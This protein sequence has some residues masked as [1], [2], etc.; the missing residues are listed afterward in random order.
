M[1]EIEAADNLIRIESISRALP[2][3]ITALFNSSADMRYATGSDY[4]ADTA[5]KQGDPECRKRKDNEFMSGIYLSGT[6]AARHEIVGIISGT[7][8][9]KNV[10][11]RQ[12]AI[13]PSLRRRGLGTRSAALTLQYARDRYRTELAFLSVV[14]DNIAGFSFWKNLGFT[15]AKRIRKELFGDKRPYS[16]AIMQKRL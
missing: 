15:Q 6:G 3:E 5:N 10:W 11:I 16:I 8:A 1:I 13:H 9:G 14:E 12:L 7:I 4:T 2:G